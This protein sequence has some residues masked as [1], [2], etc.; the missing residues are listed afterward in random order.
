MHKPSILTV[1]C[2]LVAMAM[3]TAKVPAA[4]KTNADPK[5][6]LPAV[7]AEQWAVFETSFTSGRAFG[8]VSASAGRMISFRPP[9]TMN[10]IGTRTYTVWPVLVRL[11][12][13]IGTIG[14]AG[15]R[16]GLRL[17]VRPSAS[18]GRAPAGG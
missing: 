12:A 3:G 7:D 5:S 10:S 4:E 13:A 16:P 8:W 1:A 14:R 11:H 2:L 15:P 9:R 17:G 18:F 6:A